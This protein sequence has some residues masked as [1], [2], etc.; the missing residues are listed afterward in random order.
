MTIGTILLG[1]VLGIFTGQ[2]IALAIVWEEL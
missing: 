2:V 1:F